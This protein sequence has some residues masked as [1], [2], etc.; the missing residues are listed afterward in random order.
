[1][2]YYNEYLRIKHLIRHSMNF[3][4]WRYQVRRKCNFIC[5]ICGKFGDSV[6]HKIPLGTIIRMFDLKTKKSI[7][8]CKLLWDINWG[9]NLCS[10]CH[11]KLEREMQ[12]DAEPNEISNT[13]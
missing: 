4:H 8:N 12:L 6:H 9:E 10:E 2:K 11:A 1:M 5:Q 13:I 7:Y 3:F